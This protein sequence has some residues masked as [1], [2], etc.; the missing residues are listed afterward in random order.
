MARNN[1]STKKAGLIPN[2]IIYNGPNLWQQVLG[3]AA[4][5]NHLIAKTGILF[6]HHMA[7]PDPL[8]QKEIGS[9]RLSFDQEEN[10]QFSRDNTNFYR[11]NNFIYVPRGKVYGTF[12]GNSKTLLEIASGLESYSGATLSVNR[13]YEDTTDYARISEFDK[14]I[15]CGLGKEFL[16]TNW[17]KFVPSRTRTDRMQFPVCEVQFMIDANGIQYAQGVD[18]DLNNG[19]IQWKEGAGPGTDPVSGNGVICSI[20]YLYK[21]YFYCKNV[22]H[23]IRMF[24]SLNNNVPAS[25]ISSAPQLIQ[26]QSDFI[27][28]DRR[29]AEASDP[30]QQQDAADGGNVGPR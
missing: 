6:V 21:P 7:I 25:V 29:N 2:P 27:F 26:I 9:L 12:T 3:D 24:P 11:E 13:Y 15:P 20:R 30:A 28:L 22:M 16:S 18:F 17:Q 8:F 10:F 23:D 4:A 19:V 14:L 1:Q 5:N